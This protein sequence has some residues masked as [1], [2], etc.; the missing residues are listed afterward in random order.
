M[1]QFNV[2]D[3]VSVDDF[4]KSHVPDQFDKMTEGADMSA[5]D[6]KEFKLQFE[7]DGKK[8]CLNIKNGKEV[9]IIEGGVDGAVLSLSLSEDDWR[10]A[11][12]GKLEGVI[13]RFIDPTQIADKTMLG[14]LLSTKGKLNVQL[15][16]P[17]GAQMPVS[18]VFNGQQSPEATINLTLD[19]WVAMQK[20]EANGQT[21]VMS[22][23]MTF[24]GDMMF[25]MNLQQL[26]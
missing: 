23:K 17:D 12:T 6:G 15:K 22:G 5:L 21:L 16:K 7:V 24:S 26:M 9:E 18:M 10:A 14:S 11:V 3:D 13:D 25:L 1:V 4:F 20:G 2:P 8:Y 19:D